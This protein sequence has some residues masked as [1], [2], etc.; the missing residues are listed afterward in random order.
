MENA[1]YSP[2][3]KT[4]PLRYGEDILFGLL[5]NVSSVEKFIGGLG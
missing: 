3:E 5:P 4:T 1:I 2:I